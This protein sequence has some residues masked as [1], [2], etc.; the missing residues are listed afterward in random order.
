L[1]R[2][3]HKASKAIELMSGVWTLGMYLSLGVIPM[4]VRAGSAFVQR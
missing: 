2:P 3:T 4:A 1:R